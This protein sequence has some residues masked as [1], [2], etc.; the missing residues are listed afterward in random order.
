MTCFLADFMCRF[1]TGS[2]MFA[3]EWLAVAW[4]WLEKTLAALGLS[5]DAVILWFHG[6]I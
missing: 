2:R 1:R 3:V 4:K 5:L 6:M